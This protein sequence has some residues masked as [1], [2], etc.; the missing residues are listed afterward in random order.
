MLHSREIGQGLLVGAV[1]LDIR[2]EAQR[3]V[4]GL[5]VRRRA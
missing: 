3:F 5:A 4:G 1:R 2:V